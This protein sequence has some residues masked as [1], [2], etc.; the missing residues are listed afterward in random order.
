M[1]PYSIVRVLYALNL[2]AA[3][4]IRSVGAGLDSERFELELETSEQDLFD[5]GF[6]EHLPWGVGVSRVGLSPKGWR[7]LGTLGHALTSGA[8]CC[9]PEPSSDRLPCITA[10][11][12]CA[13]RC[14]Q[15]GRRVGPSPEYL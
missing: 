1:K 15:C 2:L 9:C 13:G 3:F 12:D 14:T 4:G 6:L 8:P 7:M 5:L 10:P 11:C